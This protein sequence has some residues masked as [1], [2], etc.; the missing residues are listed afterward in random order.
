MLLKKNFKHV[1][2]CIINVGGR[3]C[4]ADENYMEV[5]H[6]SADEILDGRHCSVVEILD[7]RR[8]SPQFF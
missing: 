5:R 8:F 1:L 4:S 7:I 2:F 6:G 3:H